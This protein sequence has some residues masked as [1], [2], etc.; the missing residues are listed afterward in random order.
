MGRPPF[1]PGQRAPRLTPK[2]R[3][4][5]LLTIAAGQVATWAP[6]R[7]ASAWAVR[8]GRGGSSVIVTF[9]DS[10]GLRLVE[11]GYL[12]L[13]PDPKKAL[14][15]GKGRVGRHY[16]ATAAGLARIRT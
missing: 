15:R 1:V 13:H 2:Q 10:V 9:A 11:L 6:I 3:E 16:V 7:F 8:V 4:M 5:L 14:V 12:E